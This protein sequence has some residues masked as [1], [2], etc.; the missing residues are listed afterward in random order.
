M[1]NGKPVVRPVPTSTLANG[2]CDEQTWTI[3]INNCKQF[4]NYELNVKTDVNDCRGYHF[5]RQMKTLCRA[6][7]EV[8]CTFADGTKCEVYTGPTLKTITKEGCPDI[9]CIDQTPESCRQAVLPMTLNCRIGMIERS[10]LI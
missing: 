7:G 8:D 10:S 2:E 6:P 9:T 4:F 1:N 3:P 5:E